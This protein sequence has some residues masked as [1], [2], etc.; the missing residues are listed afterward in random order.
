MSA[1]IC[2]FTLRKSLGY[3]G[4]IVAEFVV[5]ERT[6]LLQPVRIDISVPDMNA[7][8]NI[9]TTNFYSLEEGREKW[10][11]LKK[12]GYRHTASQVIS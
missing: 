6:P 12:Q 1:G 4:E 2:I 8:G 10:K 5:D 11:A 9:R 3:S 7:G